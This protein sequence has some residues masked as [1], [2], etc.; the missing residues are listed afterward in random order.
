VPD[1]CI[2]EPNITGGQ[3]M[4]IFRR[5]E[6]GREAGPR[7]LWVLAVVLVLAGVGLAQQVLDSPTVLASAGVK[8]YLPFVRKV[9]PPVPG[10]PVLHSIDNP[11]GDGNYTA[12]WDAA[13]RANSYE[14]E[15][16]WQ[17]GDWF[18]AYTGSATQVE[19]RNRVPGQYVYRCRAQNSW[20]YSPWSN[21]QAVSVPGKAPGAISTPGST[22]VS[23]GGKSVIKVINDCPYVLRLDF[24]GPEPWPM[25]LPKCD[26]CKVY[27]LIGPIFCPTANRPTNEIRVAPGPYRVF[28]SVDDP[29][30]TPWVGHW[31]LQP[32]RRYNVCFFIVRRW[33]TAD[34]SSRQVVVGTCD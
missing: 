14:L 19:L 22:S 31:D 9:F 11:D 17:G 18:R 10:T 6:I 25:Q 30:V 23:A 21:L 7:W 15:E 24:A 16:Q 32:N 5:G 26:V 29:S 13:D 28:V 27:S 3:V 34:E 4:N 2:V 20:G 1:H 33:G 8:L 12:R